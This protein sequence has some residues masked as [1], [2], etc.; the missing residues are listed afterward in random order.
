MKKLLTIGLILLS[1]KGYSQ[2]K[3]ERTNSLVLLAYTT[4]SCGVTSYLAHRSDNMPPQVMAFTIGVPLASLGYVGYTHRKQMRYT[5]KR[6]K[7]SITFRKN[8]AIIKSK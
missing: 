8:K 4:V 6:I 7:N 1:F 2:T 3:E 5:Y